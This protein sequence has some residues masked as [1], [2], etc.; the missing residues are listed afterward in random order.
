MTDSVEFVVNGARTVLQVGPERTLLSLLRG[1]L[2]L[3]GAKYG[4]GEGVCGACTVLV[5]NEPA[6]A[7]VVPVRDVAGRSVTTIEGLARTDVLHPVQRAFVECGAMQCGFCTS[8]MIMSAVALLQKYPQPD[9]QQ[10]KSEMEGNI[11]RCCTYPRIVRAIRRAAQL[12]QSGETSARPAAYAPGMIQ[13]EIAAPA[14]G[15]WDLA[16]PKAREYFPTLSD[17]LVVVLS[18]DRRAAGRRGGWPPALEAWLHVGADGAVTAFTGKVEMGQDN[19]TALCQ[20]V[21]EELRVPLQSVRL[22]M[23]DTD[24]VPFDVGTYGSRS[25]PDA[26]ESLSSAAA[27]A[28][29]LLVE[30]A[31]ERWGVSDARLTAEAGAIRQAGSAH[32]VVYGELLRGVRRLE[33][34]TKGMTVTPKS[35]WTT[36][37]A[38]LTKLTGVEVVTG[39]LRYISDLSRPGM[40]YGRLLQ[41]PAYGAILRALDLSRA[42]AMPGVTVVHADSFVGV[43]APERALA[44]RAADAIQAEWDF[45]PQASERDLADY[46]RAHPIEGEGWEGAV[47]HETGPVDEA[48]AAAATRL[49]ATYTSAYISHVPME[50]RSVLAEWQGERLTV[51]SGTQ[52][53]FVTRA[54]IAEALQIPETSVRVIVPATGGGFGGKTTEELAVGAARLARASKKPVKITCSRQEEFTGGHFRPAAIISVQSGATA[55]GTLS[56]WEFKTYNAGSAAI[57]T[58]YDIPNQHIDYQPCDSPLPQGPYRALAATANHFARESHMDELA[59]RLQADPLEF[60]LRHL[61]DERLKAVFRAAAERAGWAGRGR[62]PGHGMGIAGGVEKGGRVATVVEVRML[63]DA[64]LQIVRIVTAFECGAIVNPDNLENQVEGATVMGLGG[65]LFEA[66]HFEGGRVLNA[67]L[68]MYRVPRFSDVPPIEVVLLDRPDQPSA[69]GGETPIVAVAP[70]LANALCEAT[71]S[72]IRSMPLLPR[73]R[74]A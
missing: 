27:T 5:D 37:G 21:A 74:L 47:H 15:P 69:G 28:R 58:P 23:G 2:G 65:A 13:P 49:S 34:V 16:R 3:T 68:A 50:T 45:A 17:G 6:R 1:E 66:I 53:P 11:C 32:S 9:E 70:A 36:A 26:G 64:R 8:G 72:R 33:V 39:S 25:M 48:L 40:L 31:A 41:P 67:N 22:I 29:Q 71:G 57:L 14:G 38:R 59:L 46:L 20:L 42:Q 51:W 19:R 44:Q 56:A 12:L 24:V 61:S 10:V 73:G 30:M 4:C 43:A 54:G 18:P 55:D 52:V 35:G 60:R 7:C 63:A 62:Q